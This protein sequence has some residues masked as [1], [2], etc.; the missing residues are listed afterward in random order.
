[1]AERPPNRQRQPKRR[2]AG[3]HPPKRP[4]KAQPRK[5]RKAPTRPP[6]VQ[7]PSV[8]PPANPGTR[9]LTIRDA[10]I[11]LSVPANNLRR[12]LERHAQSVADGGTEAEIDGLRARKFGRQ[13]RVMLG[14]A[15]Q[16]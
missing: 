13:W 9:W 2:D 15:W 7:S 14:N 16:I 3:N 5:A 8:Q 1:M 6:R 12:T 4:A 11:V 10:A